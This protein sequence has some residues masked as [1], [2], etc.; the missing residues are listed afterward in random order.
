M[1]RGSTLL[2]LPRSVSRLKLLLL[3]SALLS[4]LGGTAG[5]R[6]AQAPIALSTSI[7]T[8]AKAA[9]VAE[10]AIAARP[11]QSFAQPEH[12][13]VVIGAALALAPAIPAFASR[14]RE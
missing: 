12:A 10:R 4:A 7:T 3:L 13:A 11:V 2:N 14:R 9:A 6:A 1:R 5:A 8:V